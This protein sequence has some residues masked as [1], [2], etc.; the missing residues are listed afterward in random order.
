MELSHLNFVFFDDNL[1]D[2]SYSLWMEKL[3]LVSEDQAI[4]HHIFYNYGIG[5]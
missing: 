4:K 2:D 1:T 5:K 3:G